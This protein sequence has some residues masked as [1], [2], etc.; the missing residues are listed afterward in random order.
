MW[1]LVRQSTTKKKLNHEIQNRSD[2]NCEKVPTCSD[3]HR[4]HRPEQ[5]MD[6]LL[7]PRQSPGCQISTHLLYLQLVCH[8]NISD[9]QPETLPSF[10][11]KSQNVLQFSLGHSQ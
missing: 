11:L 8:A 10:C 4:K 7:G 2:V 3:S 5:T 9:N 1:N 6:Q